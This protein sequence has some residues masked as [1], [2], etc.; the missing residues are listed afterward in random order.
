MILWFSVYFFVSYFHIPF[1]TTFTLEQR[2]LQF[3]LTRFKIGSKYTM[4]Q[5]CLPLEFAARIFALFKHFYKDYDFCVK[6]GFYKPDRTYWIYLDI[7]ACKGVWSR[8]WQ[9]M[10]AKKPLRGRSL[11]N[12]SCLPWE[13]FHHCPPSEKHVVWKQSWCPSTVPC[14]WTFPRVCS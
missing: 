4:T 9:C 7:S 6:K 12:Q 5:A 11:L 2:H 8:S 10:L 14:P 3:L 1:W 13:S